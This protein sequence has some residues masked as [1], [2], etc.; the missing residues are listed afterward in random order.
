MTRHSSRSSREREGQ[1]KHTA[2]CRANFREKKSGCVQKSRL[3]KKKPNVSFRQGKKWAEKNK[4]QSETEA[5]KQRN[6]KFRNI[7]QKPKS[8]KPV[9]PFRRKDVA[10]SNS[11]KC[12]IKRK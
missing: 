7:L 11:K 5:G 4:R 12:G 3:I 1:G 10:L 8:K 6:G 2:T 9:E